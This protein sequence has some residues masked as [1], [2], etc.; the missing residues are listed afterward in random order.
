[1]KYDSMPVVFEVM[2]SGY[3][4]IISFTIYGQIVLE[5]TMPI[6]LLHNWKSGIVFGED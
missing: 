2:R 5:P 6:R 4:L 3:N 1:M